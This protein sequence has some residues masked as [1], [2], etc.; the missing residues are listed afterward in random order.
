MSLRRLLLVAAL[1]L[2]L[3][4]IAQADTLN[5]PKIIVG[6]TGNAPIGLQPV[7]I[8][9]SSFSFISPSGTSPGTS[10]CVVNGQ[11]DIDCTFINNDTQGD[12][13][14]NWLTLQ[15]LIS[16]FQNGI[17]CDPGPFF[18][19]CNVNEDGSVN[20]SGGSGIPFGAEFQ[21]IVEGFDPNTGFTGNANVPEPAT[22]VLL[23]TGAGAIIRRRRS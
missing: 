9:G 8:F 12:H 7:P 13:S 21:M 1:T 11:D 14:V 19:V 3:A 5:D 15:F 6:G 10:P 4:A 16:P 2:S 22:L 23:L 17:T 20:F 18:A